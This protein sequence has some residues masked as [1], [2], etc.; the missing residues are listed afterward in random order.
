MN[1]NIAVDC[2]E[3]LANLHS[4]LIVFHNKEYGTNLKKEDF[5]SYSF[6]EVWGGTVNEETKKVSQ[7]FD[8]NYFKEVI[9]VE[10]SQK[11]MDFL[12]KKGHNLFVVTGRIIS[13]TEET[14]VWI[15]K[16]FPNIFLGI[17]FGNTYGSGIKIR[18]SVMC[19]RLN[20]RLIIE[21]DLM[22]VADCANADI[23][24]LVYDNPWNQGI[25]PRKAVRVFDWNHAINTIGDFACKAQW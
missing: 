20:V 1:I 19:K 9:P 5:T 24:V 25:L 22:H 2:D 4:Q 13:L 15:E 11:A 6:H 21:D 17:C 8:S 10:G 18:K 16:Y 23:P 7:F 3:I 12:K 14:I